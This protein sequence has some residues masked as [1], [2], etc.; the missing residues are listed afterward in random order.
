MFVKKGYLTLLLAAT[1]VLAHSQDSDQYLKKLPQEGFV[2]YFVTQ[3]EFHSKAGNVRMEADFTFRYSSGTPDS[4]A[5]R[6]STFSKKPIRQP[7]GLAFFTG[8]EQVGSAGRPELL[9][10][11]K[12]KRNWHSRFSATLPYP[13]FMQLLQAGADAAIGLSAEGKTYTFTPGKNW[14]KACEVI[15][16]ILAVEIR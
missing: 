5:M 16:E 3:N 12:E 8:T 10:F 7:D 9:F 13:V 11:Q 1:A 14:R 6:F 2:L 15:R 4:V